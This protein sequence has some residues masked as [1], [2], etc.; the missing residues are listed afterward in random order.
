MLKGCVLLVEQRVNTQALDIRRRTPLH[1]AAEGGHAAV[2]QLLADEA[3]VN[4]TSADEVRHR[5]TSTAACWSGSSG[6][7]LTVLDGLGA[8]YTAA[9]SCDE[10]T[11]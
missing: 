11:S 7:I 2:V 1:A 5:S 8:A 9:R 10:W 4:I 3:R 6:I